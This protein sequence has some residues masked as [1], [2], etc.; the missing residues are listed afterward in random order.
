MS[1]GAPGT[2][3]SALTALS[4]LDHMSLITLY[5]S[6]EIDEHRTFFEIGDLVDGVMPRDEYIDEMLAMSMS[7]T[8]EIVQRELASPF[9]LF[10]VSIIE[11]AKDV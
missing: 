5:L 10:R 8:E 1:D 4:S 7:Q 3:T 11:I 9:Y 2:S 6:N